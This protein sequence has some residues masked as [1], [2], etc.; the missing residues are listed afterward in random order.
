[1]KKKNQPVVNSTI[2]S[3]CNVTP[4]YL[5]NSKKIDPAAKIYS[6]NTPT[7]KF[8]LY[9]NDVQI[10]LGPNVHAVNVTDNGINISFKK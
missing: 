8:D 2:S 3:S 6:L 1:M 9:V 5:M 7:K 4:T 10:N